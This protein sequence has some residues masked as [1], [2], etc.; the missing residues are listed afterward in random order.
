MVNARATLFMPIADASGT[1][2]A[3]VRRWHAAL[4]DREVT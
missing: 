2:A 4:I 1:H 3:H